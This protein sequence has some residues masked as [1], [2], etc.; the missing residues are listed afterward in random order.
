MVNLPDCFDPVPEAVV[1][2]GVVVDED[3]LAATQVVAQLQHAFFEAQG[4]AVAASGLAVPTRP[5]QQTSRRLGPEP[6]VDVQL[7]AH[8]PKK[9]NRYRLTS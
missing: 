5:Q 2:P 1:H 9:F 7:V 8:D 4:E 3:D 6:D